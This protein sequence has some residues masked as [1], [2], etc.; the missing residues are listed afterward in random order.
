MKQAMIC[1]TNQHNVLYVREKNVLRDKILITELDLNTVDSLG[2]TE[3][4]T[5]IQYKYKIQY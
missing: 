1:S 2:F 5:E 4:K 3:N